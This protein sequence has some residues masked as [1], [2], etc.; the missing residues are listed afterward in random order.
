MLK[1]F[2]IASALLAA[3]AIPALAEPPADLEACLKL[4]GQIAKKAG[5][6][7]NSQADYLKFHFKFMDLNSACGLKDFAG[8][9]KAANDIKATFRLD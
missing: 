8:A 5:D 3:L 1:I 4:S 6:K 9:E 2:S 7:I